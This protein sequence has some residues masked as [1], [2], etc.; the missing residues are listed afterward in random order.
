MAMIEDNLE[1]DQMGLVD[2]PE[3]GLFLSPSSLSDLRKAVR[4]W[5]KELPARKT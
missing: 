3:P 2:Y 5:V 1:P 4:L